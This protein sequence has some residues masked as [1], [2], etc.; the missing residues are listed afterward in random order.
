MS[1]WVPTISL[2]PSLYN[3][4]EEYLKC[5]KIACLLYITI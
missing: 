3:K 1:Q 4:D 2:Y 5:Y